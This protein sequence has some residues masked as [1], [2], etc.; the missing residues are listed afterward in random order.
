M[1]TVAAPAIVTTL[2]SNAVAIMSHQL[3]GGATGRPEWSSQI[4]TEDLAGAS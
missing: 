1:S 3:G 4:F 2:A